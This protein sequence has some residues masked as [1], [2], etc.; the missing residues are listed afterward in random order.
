MPSIIIL[1]FTITILRGIPGKKKNSLYWHFLECEGAGQDTHIATNEHTNYDDMFKHGCWTIHSVATNNTLKLHFRPT[2]RGFWDSDYLKKQVS[3]LNPEP[4][5]FWAVSQQKPS[6]LCAV[7]N[8]RVVGTVSNTTQ[9]KDNFHLRAL[10]T[11]LL[12]AIRHFVI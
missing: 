8:T 6:T 2:A 12:Q 10:N 4:V 1:W 9:R 11:C 5:V 7:A 3:K